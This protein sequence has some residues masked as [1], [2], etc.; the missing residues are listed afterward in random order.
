MME[1]IRNN[2]EWYD[3]IVEQAKER[4]ITVEENLR[5]NAAYIIQKEKKKHE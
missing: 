5:R 2:Q 4:G 1:D 3:L